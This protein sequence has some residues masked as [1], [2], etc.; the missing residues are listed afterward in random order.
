M[1]YNER[2]KKIIESC[3][4]EEIKK[5]NLSFLC[6]TKKRKIP[7]CIPFQKIGEVNVGED[8]IVNI[9][10]TPYVDE[11]GEKSYDI[12]VSTNHFIKEKNY[13][14]ICTKLYNVYHKNKFNKFMTQFA[15]CVREGCKAAHVVDVRESLV[16]HQKRINRKYLLQKKDILFKHKAC[17]FSY[18]QNRESAIKCIDIII[19]KIEELTYELEVVNSLF[20]SNPRYVKGEHLL[21]VKNHTQAAYYGK[22]LITREQTNKLLREL[23]RLNFLTGLKFLLENDKKIQSKHFNEM[24]NLSIDEDNYFADIFTNVFETQNDE[25]FQKER[26]ALL[27]KEREEALFKESRKKQNIL[28]KLFNKNVKT[29]EKEEVKIIKTEVEEVETEEETL[30]I[31][32]LTA[33]LYDLIESKENYELFK[34]SIDQIENKNIY[35]VFA[36]L[37]KLIEIDYKEI[38][39]NDNISVEEKENKLFYISSKLILIEETL[40]QLTDE[41]EVLVTLIDEEEEYNQIH[42]AKKSA[43]RIYLEEDLKLIPNEY[44]ST[45]YKLLN[46]LATGDYQ[47]VKTKKY[48]TGKSKEGLFE[49]KLDALRLFYYNL[50]NNNYQVILIAIKKADKPKVLVEKVKNRIVN[51]SVELN[52]LKENLENNTLTES[53]IDNENDICVNLLNTLMSNK[54]EMD[55]PVVRT[56]YNRKN[57]TK[58]R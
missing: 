45:A 55:Y 39:I 26:E 46:A 38:S 27:K 15:I 40:N 48:I 57:Y 47:G 44:Y 52:E 12:T 5:R 2:I 3:T 1:N 37:K 14:K 19:E 36:D 34:N 35:K 16:Y 21:D 8:F 41:E 7:S 6:A 51:T 33:Y 42:F 43:G 25:I 4:L 29:E 17:N 11:D 49:V 31:S 10:Y 56:K 30:E 18:Y 13:R 20:E 54:D 28:N 24:L 53:Y 58:K 22:L 23:P 9:K 32:N 50:G